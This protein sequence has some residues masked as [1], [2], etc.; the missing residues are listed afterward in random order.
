[1][2]NISQPIV[3]F[4]TED[5]SLIT[6]KAL[7]DAGYP[8]AAVV[9]KPDS[10]QGRGHIL[11]EPPVK[12]LAK[13]HNIPV[14]QPAKLSEIT[15]SVRALK[16][17][18][19]ILV[20][21]GKIIPQSI[22]ELFTPGI[23]NVHPSLLPKYRGP[24]PIESA[25]ISGDRETGV[26]IMKLSAAMDAGP[27]YKQIITPLNGSK[28]ATELYESLGQ[29]G[30]QLI[31]ELLPSIVNGSLVP[32]KQDE[33]K[34]SY[35]QLIQKS[36]GII[37]WNE[38]ATII[39]AR[40]RAYELWPKSRTTLGNTDVIITKTHVIADHYGEPGT[41]AIN[42]TPSHAL[43]VGAGSGAISIESLKP[44]GKKEMPVTAFLSGYGSQLA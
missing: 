42:P 4:G 31:V 28:T 2:T 27:V 23:I 16:N 20:S 14:W 17:P 7:I 26:S 39:E 35:C 3:F 10:P 36:D 6:L 24:S 18:V 33:T 22:I 5:F 21:Y 9:T 34:V 8:V 30:A 43:V 12:V 41:I 44:V 25:I 11:T 32:V 38:D 15:E 13:Q 29:R 40:I 37:D 1:M 19:G